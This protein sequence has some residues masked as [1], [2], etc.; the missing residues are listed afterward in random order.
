MTNPS[1]AARAELENI[2][3]KIA[4]L[5]TQRDAATKDHAEA[6]E[7]FMAGKLTAEQ[8]Q[9]SQGRLNTIE[10][11]ILSL[12]EFRPD[13]ARKVESA[14][15][16][17]SIESLLVDMV[18]SSTGAA[19]ARK[20]YAEKFVEAD[21][22]IAT[23]AADLFEAR[24]AANTQQQAFAKAKEQFLRLSGEMPH[25]LEQILKSKGVSDSDLQSMIHFLKPPATTYGKLIALAEST[26][27]SRLQRQA[28]R[29]TRAIDVQYRHKD[30]R[31]I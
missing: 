19:K 3:T 16:K 7:K 2:D 29:E 31:T 20:E 28:D 22:A 14:D 26:H 21:L 1:Q 25:Q 10:A 18:K 17:A 6:R 8:F 9:A 30:D 11:S 24:T 27:G 5:E 15:T 23:A 12:R 13:I 4:E